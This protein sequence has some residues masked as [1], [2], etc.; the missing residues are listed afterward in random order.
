MDRVGFAYWS[1]RN[2]FFIYVI[3]SHR[4]L[5]GYFAYIVLQDQLI[6]EPVFWPLEDPFA[7]TV[8]MPP[9]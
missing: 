5:I 9:V 4:C 3:S 8:Q 7:V 2:S 1:V 6:F